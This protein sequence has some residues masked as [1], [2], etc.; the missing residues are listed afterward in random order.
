M[1]FKT[2]TRK[3]RFYMRVLNGLGSVLFVCYGAII[4]SLSL[5]ILNTIVIG[6]NL[7]YIIKEEGPTIKNRFGSLKDKEV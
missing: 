7:F 5:I 4:H 6:V 1:C 2:T 3:G